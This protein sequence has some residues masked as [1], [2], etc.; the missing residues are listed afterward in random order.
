M[1]DIA[2]LLLGEIS[3]RP[4]DRI[5]QFSDLEIKRLSLTCFPNNVWHYIP[6]TYKDCGDIL[7]RLVTCV[8]SHASCDLEHIFHLRHL[9]L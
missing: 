6:H 7:R 4:A 5:E 1:A 2:F 9:A 8:L 3:I